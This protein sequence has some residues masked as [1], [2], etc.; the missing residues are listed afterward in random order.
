[1]KSALVNYSDSDSDDSKDHALP[2]CPGRNLKRKR[3]GLDNAVSGL[4]PLPATFHDLYASTARVSSQDDPSMHA[5]RQRV[6]PHVEG[7]WP[8]HVYLECKLCVEGSMIVQRMMA[9]GLEGI[10]LQQN[11]TSY[12]TSSPFSAKRRVPMKHPYTVC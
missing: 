1:M 3:D 7:S 10:L 2:A 5:G 4:P 9:N 8:T 12:L 6:L 11:R